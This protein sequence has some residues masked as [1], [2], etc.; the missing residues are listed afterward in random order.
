MREIRDIIFELRGMLTTGH[1]FR[2]LPL[3]LLAQLLSLWPYI[4]S[5]FAPAVLATFLSLE[6]FY[7]NMLNIWAGQ[8]TS[9]GIFPT[10]WVSTLRRRNIAVIIVTWGVLAFYTILVAYVQPEP[11]APELFGALV[12]YMAS[13]QFPL[14]MIGNS[15]S[16]Q[17]VRGRNGWG[18]EDA[19]AAL[20]ML[21]GVGISSLPFFALTGIP[22]D[23]IILILY[24]A[25]AAAFWWSRSV[26]RAARIIHERYP[27]LW[28]QTH[29]TSF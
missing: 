13:I 25:A 5:P 12:L 20:I 23:G 6:P 16:W 10:G 3:S 2:L 9:G 17:Q 1:L 27:D 14:L 7:N 11:V 21:V 15:F 18:L 22:G 19:A 4:G 29:L 24:T 8:M 28:Q 26:P